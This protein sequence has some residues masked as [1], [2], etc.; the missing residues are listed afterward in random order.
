MTLELKKTKNGNG[1]FSKH[2]IAPNQPIIE[3]TGDLFTKETLNKN[4]HYIQ[5]N[6]NKYIGPSR[7]TR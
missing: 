5:I 1:V 7:K 2:K 4:S 6:Y 3:F